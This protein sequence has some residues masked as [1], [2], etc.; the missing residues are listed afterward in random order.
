MRLPPGQLLQIADA[1]LA[2]VPL[3]A[4]WFEGYELA[5][6]LAIDR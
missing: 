2:R 1:D 6:K 3:L 4:A 5:G